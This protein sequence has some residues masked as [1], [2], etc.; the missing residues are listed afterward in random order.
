MT[1]TAAHPPSFSPHP[2]ALL[3]SAFA[4]GA[5]LAYL[6]EPAPAYPLAACGLASLV[7]F[8]ARRRGG[9]GAAT[10][11]LLLAYACAGAA[12]SAVERRPPGEPRLRSFYESGLLASGDP[13]EITG[14]VERAPESS[15][16]GFFFSLAVE[17]LRLGAA[18]RPCRGR[19][20]LFLPA[21]DAAAR[22]RYEALELRRGARVRVAARFAREAAYRNPG[23]ESSATH[24]DRRGT[25]ARATVKSPLLV[26]RLDD[27]AVFLP[28]YWLDEWRRLAIAGA[29]ELFSPA[30]AGVLKAAMFG[31]RRG[32]TRETAE[33][34]REG[35]TFHVLV[36][37]GLHV[38]LVGGLAWA[39]ARLLTRRRAWR[40]L[41]A[42]AAVWGFA[43]AVGAESS[44]VRAALMLTAATLAPVVGR[45]AGALNGLGGAA[46]ALLAWRPS[47]V[48]DP[49]FQLTFLSV[50]AIAALALPL[51][52]RL[53]EVGGWRPTRQTP[54]P[55]DCP[56]W[57]RAAAELL[58]WRESLW[59][60]EQEQ[61]TYSCRLFKA[62]GA[63]RLERLR[64]QAPLRWAFSALI[65]STLVQATLLPLLVLY[66]HRLPPA[67]PLLNLWVG[68]LLAAA[69]ASALAALVLWAAGGG[70]SAFAALAEAAALLAARGVDPF[71]AAGLAS[72]RPAEYAG[73]ASAVYAL[74]FVP[75]A[76]L[77]AAL[78]GWRPLGAPKAADAVTQGASSGEGPGAAGG[79]GR[80][81]AG[82]RAQRK[83]AHPGAA[84]GRRPGSAALAA[85]A[86]A[87]LSAVIVLHPLS[88]PRP[89]GRLRVDFLDVGQGDAALVTMPDGTTLL[90]DAGGRAGFGGGPSAR[91][92]GP[93]TATAEAADEAPEEFAP[94]VRG[95][96][97]RV[98]SEFL[99]H[100]GLG[101]L[102]FVLATHAHADHIRGLGDV[103]ANF[104]VGSALVARTPAG[105]EEFTAF[106]AAAARAGVPVYRVAR[107]D[108]LRF[109][110]ASVEV[111]WPP[112]DA[113]HLPP[114]GRGHGQASSSNDD[115]LVLRLSLGRR[116]I[117]LTGDIEARAEAALAEALGPALACDVLKVA[118]HGSRTSST[119][120]F[121]SA[122]RPAWAVVPAPLDSPHGH[123]HPEVLARLRAHGTRVLTTGQRG[124]VT[125]STDGEDL[126]VE[127]YIKN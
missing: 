79:G 118:H 49:A 47:S 52:A 108:V 100:R 123:P 83:G 50:L 120:K 16:D 1:G 62:R 41:A 26:E 77:A 114:N 124:T 98:V 20:E 71:A 12:L 39:A 21:A 119:E 96:G 53:K 102:D 6:A 69:C 95:V 78:A 27:R 59:R 8:F 72:L 58:F 57:L 101:R 121:L 38:T 73:A 3:A 110:A 109:G 7:S 74:Y 68:P 28:L 31:D 105:D 56:D 92:R 13:A 81:E 122:A 93:V 35:G 115:S 60:R 11:S 34:F 37:S 33:R 111:L 70:P 51:L 89:D 43:L 84:V 106:A 116:S 30:A 48:F 99:W 5:A 126:R 88:A 97:D 65:V 42:A 32:L 29:D 54:R 87:A 25:D 18:E 40:W 86:L 2:L 67:A 75:L 104:T 80:E 64:A 103:L 112:A 14:A 23:V 82:A 90:V 66:F 46:L 94:D 127:T 85:L 44:V 61:A 17:A 15:P 24:L 19:V 76:A 4:G 107:G 10:A 91:R 113:P 63:A 45:R 36:V 55:P 9:L 125:V 117:L 22:A